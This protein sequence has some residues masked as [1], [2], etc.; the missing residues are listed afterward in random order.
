MQLFVGQSIDC[1]LV[2]AKTGT[3]EAAN[4]TLNCTVEGGSPVGYVCKEQ[5]GVEFPC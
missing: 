1:M 4:I 2:D 3:T 5:C